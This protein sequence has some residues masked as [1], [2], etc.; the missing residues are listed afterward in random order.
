MQRTEAARPDGK[1]ALDGVGWRFAQ[2]VY[3]YMCIYIH[4]YIYMYICICICIYIYMYIHTYVCV[5][6]SPF[7]VNFQHLWYSLDFLK[8][9]W[10]Y[11]NVYNTC[12]H[13]D[14]SLWNQGRRYPIQLWQY[15]WGFPIKSCQWHWN[16]N[17][18]FRRWCDMTSMYRQDFLWLIDW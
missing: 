2:Y 13:L 5:C 7:E 12:L 18:I 11:C 10:A 3:I 15:H 14:N 9:I 1:A 17:S 8:P 16:W 4:I 6:V